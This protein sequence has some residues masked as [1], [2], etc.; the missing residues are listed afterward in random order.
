MTWNV[1]RPRPVGIDTILDEKDGV[2]NSRMVDHP[3]IAC[4]ETRGLAA[5]L[6][7]GAQGAVMGTRFLASTEMTVSTEWKQMIVEADATDSLK[8]EMLDVILPPY[9][10][11]A[12]NTSRFRVSQPVWSTRSSQR[13]RSCAG[14]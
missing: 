11:E 3:R 1:A 12:T 9:T 2:R 6:A 10:A 7:L 4:P 14:L 8:A 5:V 13:L